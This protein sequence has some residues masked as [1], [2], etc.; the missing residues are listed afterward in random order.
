MKGGLTALVTCL[1]LA[2]AG[3]VAFPGEGWL[4]LNK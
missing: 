3:A 2:A 4:L 1:V